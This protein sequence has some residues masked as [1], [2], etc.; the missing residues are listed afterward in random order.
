MYH[1]A[2]L[3]VLVL[4]VGSLQGQELY[5]IRSVSEA[6]LLKTYTTLLRDGCKHADGV[7]KEWSVDPKGGLWGTG[8]SDQMNEG[9]RA[10]AGM[11]LAS[12]TLLKYENNLPP[13]ERT[14]LLRKATAAIHYAV[15]THVT[16]TQKCTD[17][18]PW[19][20]SWQSAMWTGTLAFGSWMIWDE[21]DPLMQKDIERVV[22][23]ETDR[24]LNVKPPGGSWS[25]TKAE[26]NGWNMTCISLAANMFPHHPHATVWDQKAKE[27]MMNTL[28]APQDAMDKTLVDGRPVSEWF[29]GANL[30]PD[31]T[32]ENHGFFHPAYVGC[33]S[34]FMT[35]A[36]MQHTYARRPIPQAATHH[37]LDIW[38]MFQT[39]ILPCGEA[40]FPQ[41]MD[42]E[43]HGLPFINLYASLASWKKDP[44]AA[45][46]E[47]VYVQY[48]RAWQEM[49]K[50]DL[51]V[52]G[53]R[54]G[55]TRHAICAEQAAYGF[56]AHKIFGSPVKELSARDTAKRLSGVHLRDSIHVITHR[57]ENKL[58]SFS[59]TNHVM[60]MLIP[61]GAGH[62]DNPDFTTPIQNGFVGSF[63]LSPK[64]DTKTKS[65][66]HN[67]TTNAH[68]CETSGV[69]LLNGG[70]LQQTI[71]VTSLGDRTVVYQDRVI[72]L[73]NVL[74]TQEQGVPLGIENDPVTGGKRIVYSEAGEQ[75]FLWKDSSNAIAIS[76]SWAN[77]DGR[78]GIIPVQG[79]KLTY[80]PAT[81]YHPGMAVCSDLLCCS[82]SKEPRHF[83]KG[84]V[85]AERIA[86]LVVEVGPK[87][88][89]RLARKVRVDHS[90]NAAIL[91]FNL[92]EGG[93]VK[94]P[95]L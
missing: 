29:S 83:K 62:D 58:L 15:S 21:L 78:L 87:E 34:Y 91:R 40:A 67:W 71:T 56:L 16:G 25:D 74:I 48:M 11:V 1:L 47:R 65:V 27:Y 54:L 66:S 50:G 57:T 8:R 79:G 59:W 7:W 76:G 24:F 94:V 81:G 3:T 53:S 84:D 26:E 82:F 5:K 31:F 51:A 4:S 75:P 72:A 93:E 69:L 60:G 44:L 77:V 45:R 88:T 28:S 20:G 89:A 64:G 41:G 2:L 61:I 6:E 42:W 33:S 14:E 86:I 37:L 17:G 22:A 85:V 13:A 23:S 18:K 73:T 39:I 70:Q 49:C 32:L 90:G 35:Q 10:I 80:I 55:F 12:G 95:L 38:Q 92:P 30:H 63:E 43:L 52:S 68:G 19:G 9:I 36:A 46:M